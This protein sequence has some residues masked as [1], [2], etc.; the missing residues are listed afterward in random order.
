MHR[1]LKAET[2]RPPATG[3]HGQQKRFD[4]FR[5]E[6]NQERPHEALGQRP[7]GRLY[8]PAPR[9]YPERIPEV[10]YPGHYEVRKVVSGGTFM[11]HG[12]PVFVSESL[13]GEHVG[14]VEIE[15]G[16]WKVWFAG[17]ELGIVDEIDLRSRKT[18]K[19]L[20]MSPVAQYPP[21]PIS[22]LRGGRST[23]VP[24]REGQG[25]GD[26]SSVSCF[27]LPAS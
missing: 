15:D 25:V 13:E 19:V 14:L 20:P 16:L 11:W 23:P 12:Q 6:Y 9:P 2:T 5:R 17:M 8:R 10:E 7:P 21:L 27:P 1:T 18:G 26:G 4:A 3:L 24:P 22:P